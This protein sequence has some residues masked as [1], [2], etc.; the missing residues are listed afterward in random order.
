MLITIFLEKINSNFF[1]FIIAIK[2][3]KFYNK[4]IYISFN[5]KV[6]AINSRKII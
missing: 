3:V 6:K 5:Q 1:L 4:K 2:L